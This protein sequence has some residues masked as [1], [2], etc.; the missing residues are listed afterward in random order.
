MALEVR[1]VGS[2]IATTANWLANLVVSV[3]YLTELETLTPSGTYGRYLG[4]SVVFFIFAVFCYHETKQLSIDE[5]SLLFEEDFGV[6]RSR[7]MHQERREAQRRLADSEMTEVATAHVQARK[8]KNSAVA[9]SEF[10]NF[11]AGWKNDAKRLTA[12]K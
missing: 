9:G 10:E 3:L 8:Q 11:M 7:Q 12:L 2:G 6:K 1:S 4:F 5:T